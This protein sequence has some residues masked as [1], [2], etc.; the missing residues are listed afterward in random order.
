MAMIF[1]LDATLDRV[2][3]ADDAC[4]TLNK[5]LEHQTFIVDQLKI[6][7]E[8]IRKM[9]DPVE[10]DHFIKSEIE[11]VQPL[12]RSLAKDDMLEC[13]GEVMD[14]AELKQQSTSVFSKIFSIVMSLMMVI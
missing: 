14:E 10:K 5:T 6:A 1:I 2:D 12:L 8:R 3:P 7:K 9:K 11:K 13:V 4:R